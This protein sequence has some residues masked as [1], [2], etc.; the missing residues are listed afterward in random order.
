M[1]HVI[2]MHAKDNIAIVMAPS[3]AVGSEFKVGGKMV[4]AKDEL[5]FA[6]K[7]AIKAIPKGGQIVKYGEPVGIATADIAP[8]EHVHVHN[9]VSGRHT[10]KE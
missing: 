5:P 4:C 10:V 1:E 7:V 6:H 8:G 2:M 3:L 9:V